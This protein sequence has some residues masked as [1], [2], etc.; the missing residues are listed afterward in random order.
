MT[1][2]VFCRIANGEVPADV[3]WEGPDALAF[4]DH[5]PLFPGHVLLVPPE[6]H[7]TLP[8]LP[9]AQ[10]GSFFLQGQR[11]A[12]AVE[13]VLEAQGTFVAINNRVSQSVPHLHLHVV[14]RRKGDG[15]KGF[16]WPRHGYRDDA[17]RAAVAEALRRALAEG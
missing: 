6:H 3:V 13:R 17:E 16:F 5:R 12:A 8:D 11:I 4:L 1:A 7:V 9:A 10:V 15:L 14:P 2:C